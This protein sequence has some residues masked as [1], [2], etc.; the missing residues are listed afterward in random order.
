[1][2]N[3]LFSSIA[4]HIARGC[5]VPLPAP[6]RQRF[7]AVHF[8]AETLSPAFQHKPIGLTAKRT[9][10]LLCSHLKAPYP[11]DRPP[12]RPRHR[13][14]GLRGPLPH[15]AGQPCLA[16]KNRKYSAGIEP[17]LLPEKPVKSALLLIQYNSA[18]GKMVPSESLH[19]E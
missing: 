13:G 17:L 8:W 4:S 7:S 19:C 9:V 12:F 16:D 11:A 3:L 10:L 15:R 6:L 1:M 18:K 14:A 2:G 5:P